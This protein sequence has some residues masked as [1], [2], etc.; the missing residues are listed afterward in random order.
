M[1]DIRRKCRVVSVT[2][3]ILVLLAGITAAIIL[4]STANNCEPGT[5]KAN[6]TCINCPSGTYSYKKGSTKCFKCPAGNFQP[7][8]GRT[9]CDECSTGSV[10]T[11]DR[12]G[13]N[14]CGAGTH[15]ISKVPYVL[16]TLILHYVDSKIFLFMYKH[17][18]KFG[19]YN[20]IGTDY[21]NDELDAINYIFRKKRS[22]DKDFET[23][24]Y[25]SLQA[26]VDTSGSR[27][28]PLWG[29]NVFHAICKPCSPGSFG[30]KTGA[31]NSCTK[32]PSGFYQPEAGQTKCETCPTINQIQ[33][34]SDSGAT[35]SDQCEE[36]PKGYYSESAENM[37][38]STETDEDD[39]WWKTSNPKRK[40]RSY[41]PPLYNAL[42][43]STNDGSH[44]GFYCRR[45]ECVCNNGTFA[46]DEEC[47]KDG[48]TQC[49]KCDH[50]FYL[51]DQRCYEV[52]G[53]SD[54]NTDKIRVS[55][56]A[57]KEILENS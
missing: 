28:I 30:N 19:D 57:D 12:A 16:Y 48:S 29:S 36:C 46:E 50:T 2:I 56:S 40:R 5:Y 7:L 4:V 11:E 52:V 3:G 1:G 17:I 42:L 44:K 32:C 18:D 51:I 14:K 25:V 20:Y 55:S 49:S 38:N 21:D 34:I 8:E 47:L 15:E 39:S 10:S 22:L 35:R 43:D 26:Q 37:P 24:D 6:S 27:P 45:N 9:S 31:L 41:E 13:C 54:I 53:L 33:H 23:A